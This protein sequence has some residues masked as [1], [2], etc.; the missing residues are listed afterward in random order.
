MLATSSE[1]HRR[2]Q[3]AAAVLACLLVGGQSTPTSTATSTQSKTRTPT[4]TATQLTQMAPS[5]FDAPGSRVATLAGGNA[6]GVTGDLRD[7]V[8]A[9]AAVN[10]SALGAVALDSNRSFV[11]YVERAHAVVRRIDVPQGA[12]V[13][14]LA[15]VWGAPGFD[16]D[17]PQP[18]T[19]QRLSSP[20]MLA[21]DSATGD[22][23]VLDAGVSR[24]RRVS[25]ATG[26]LQTVAGGG[27]SFADGVAATSANL[28]GVTVIATAANH[29]RLYFFEATRCTVRRVDFATSSLV[30][31]VGGTGTCGAAY[32]ELRPVPFALAPLT[33][34]NATGLTM[35]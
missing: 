21:V 2:L 9:A 28:T 25:D 22:V 26:M 20:A 12:L 14:T 13:T 6:S 35:G 4:R 29:G 23:F 1:M 18:A 19:S 10:I 30:W 8:L 7:A 3:L 27:V 33:V 24:I 5:R 11:F 16:G 34:A 31:T 32:R 15:G 17:G